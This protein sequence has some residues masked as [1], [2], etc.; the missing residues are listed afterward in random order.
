[1]WFG[2]RRCFG[3]GDCSVLGCIPI[4]VVFMIISVSGNWFLVV[5][6]W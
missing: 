3:I 2:F 6:S 5:S 4:E 1:M